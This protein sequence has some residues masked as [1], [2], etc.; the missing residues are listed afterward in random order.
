[1]L[2]YHLDLVLCSLSSDSCAYRG[3]LVYLVRMLFISVLKKSYIQ[4]EN[5]VH[6]LTDSSI[7]LLP[8]S[9]KYHC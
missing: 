7:V 3:Y 4:K 9:L 1:M 5:A 8:D 6:K 2:Y